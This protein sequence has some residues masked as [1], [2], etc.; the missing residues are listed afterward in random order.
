MLYT[1]TNSFSNVENF[2]FSGNKLGQKR[3]IFKPLKSGQPF[4]PMVIAHGQKVNR[5]C[6]FQDVRYFG[7]SEQTE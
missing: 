5:R 6:C 7:E 2:G 3:A 1:H 4:L